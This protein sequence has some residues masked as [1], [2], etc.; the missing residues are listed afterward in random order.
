MFRDHDERRLKNQFGHHKDEKAFAEAAR[1][2]ANELEEIFAQDAALDA[3]EED[4]KK[5]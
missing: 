1:V 3:P 2:W 5:G 4:E